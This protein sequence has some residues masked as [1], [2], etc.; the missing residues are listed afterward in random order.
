[1]DLRRKETKR[2]EYALKRE[3]ARGFMPTTEE[4]KIKE[5]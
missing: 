2:E 4:E 1:M 3:V 5:Q